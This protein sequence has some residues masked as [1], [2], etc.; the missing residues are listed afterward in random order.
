M[1]KNI[2]FY[3]FLLAR[4]KSYYSEHINTH[5]MFVKFG[6][7]SSCLIVDSYVLLLLLLFL[8]FNKKCKPVSMHF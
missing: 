6:V 3:Y 5:D 2:N 8:I 4:M 7:Y 1:S